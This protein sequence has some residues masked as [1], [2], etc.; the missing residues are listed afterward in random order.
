MDDPLP[1]S[2][3]ALEEHGATLASA[4]APGPF[5]W[6][7]DLDGI[8]EKVSEVG[9]EAEKS[10]VSGVFGLLEVFEA[11]G[12]FS[13]EAG[14]DGFGFLESVFRRELASGRCGRGSFGVGCVG[15]VAFSARGSGRGEGEATGAVDDGGAEVGEAARSVL[16]YGREFLLG[17]VVDGLALKINRV[18]MEVRR[19]T[20]KAVVGVGTCFT[21]EPKKPPI[22]AP[23]GLEENA[24]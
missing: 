21:T 13:A 23:Q 16:A 12:G 7:C 5:C 2:V 24:R 6:G 19:A 14:Q 4:A 1:L 17:F 18:S 9:S 10:L 15:G 8:F 3:L 22:L 20:S 11:L